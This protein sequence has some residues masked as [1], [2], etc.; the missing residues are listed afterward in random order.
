ML[1]NNALQGVNAGYI[2]K[3]ALMEDHLRRQQERISRA[4]LQAVETSR[5]SHREPVLV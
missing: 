2:T 5:G 3:G 4:V 1:M